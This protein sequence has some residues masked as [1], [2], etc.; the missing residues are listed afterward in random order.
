MRVI[1]KP[2]ILVFTAETEDESAQF[3]A[4]RETIQ[5]H[6]FYFYGGSAKGGSLHDLGPREEA[7]REPINIV[8]D[9]AGPWL[10]ISNLAETPFMIGD[11]TYASIEGFWQGLKYPSEDERR[12]VAVLSGRE[13]KFAAPKGP[14]PET[15]NFDGRTYVT[16]GAGHRALMLQ[17]CRAKFTQH[18]TAQEALL[19]TGERPL[20]HRVRRD[21]KTIPGV[22]MADIWMRIRSWL[23]N[24]E[25]E[26]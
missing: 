25:A 26:A 24:R 8:Y 6:V 14:P 11:K 16:G 21:S 10:P 13:A 4:W 1:F 2:G 7:C 12:R 19:S 17:A 15:F 18:L 20:T 23:R 22:V 3:S 5:G 9:N